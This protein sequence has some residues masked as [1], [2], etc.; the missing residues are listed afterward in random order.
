MPGVP[1]IY[2]GDEF[3][4]EGGNDPDN[5]RFM[6]FSGYNHF[7]QHNLDEVRRF[8]QLRRNNIALQFGDYLPLYVDDNM[9]VYLRTYMG[10]GV[11]VAINNA[12]T[13]VD[14]DVTIPSGLKGTG[15][16]KLHVEAN[17]VVCEKL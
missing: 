9:L 5:R 10:E 12:K 6:R 13:A 16:R 15:D 3:G 14:V 8:T 1:C 17:D 11:L 4:Q 7:E 2:Q